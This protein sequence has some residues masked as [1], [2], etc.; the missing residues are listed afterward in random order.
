MT[1]FYVTI[2]RNFTSKVR[3]CAVS[4]NETGL[5]IIYG[6][7]WQW[8]NGTADQGYGNFE[9]W[10][11]VFIIVVIILLIIQLILIIIDSFVHLKN[12]KRLFKRKN[13]VEDPEKYN[14]LEKEDE[15]N[16]DES[17]VTAKEVS[18]PSDPENAGD[19]YVFDSDEFER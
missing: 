9:I 6:I 2:A 17:D 11:L 5:L 8:L 7:C 1:V 10:G 15:E 4:V 12:I 14:Q 3:N 13:V 18:L 16:S 19:K